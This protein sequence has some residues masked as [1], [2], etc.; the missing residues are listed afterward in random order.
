R[1][2]QRLSAVSRTRSR[3]CTGRTDRRRAMKQTKIPGTGRDPATVF[4]DIEEISQ[5]Y[6][7]ARDNRMTLSR[8]EQT[9]Q[10]ELIGAMDRRGLTTYEC[11]ETEHTITVLGKRR[12]KVAKRGG[13]EKVED[14]EA[15][16]FPGSAPSEAVA[17]A[18]APK[19]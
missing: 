12:A 19:I 5:K 11:D 10:Q 4:D 1:D 9:F 17:Q 18:S 14:E 7:E 16:T 8:E 6:V 3:N 13:E 15:Y 2:N